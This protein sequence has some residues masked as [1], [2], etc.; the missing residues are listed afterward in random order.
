MSRVGPRDTAPE[1]LVRRIVWQLGIRYRLHVASLPGRPD[2]V[3]SR[4]RKIIDVRGCF[5]H[6]HGCKLT[7]NPKSNRR[8]WNAKF[9]ATVARDERNAKMLKAAGWKVLVVW[10]CQLANEEKAK[11]RIE[12]FLFEKRQRRKRGR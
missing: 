2:V 10:Q 1:L 9:R 11:A 12:K 6:R 4:L 7:T 8:F 5:W 3:I